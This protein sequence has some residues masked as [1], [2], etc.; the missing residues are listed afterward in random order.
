MHAFRSF[1][2]S[3]D[4]QN[5]DLRGVFRASP[6]RLLAWPHPRPPQ[7]TQQILL[8]PFLGLT[9]GRTWP[10]SVTASLRNFA[11]S[12]A[13]SNFLR[14]HPHRAGRRMGG[15]DSRRQWIHDIV[16]IA[17]TAPDPL[18]A[19]GRP[20]WEPCK[21]DID[22]RRSVA[23]RESWARADVLRPEPPSSHKSF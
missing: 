14:F 5:T 22:Y 21:S 23:H 17:I 7:G 12:F 2:I 4:H 20:P 15:G 6:R 10:G 1:A 18:I 16:V 13:A 9:L 8:S 3:S 19:D 11:F